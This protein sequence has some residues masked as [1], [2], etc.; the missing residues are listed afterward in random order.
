MGKYKWKELGLKYD[1]EDVRP[2]NDNDIENAK[3]ILGMSQ[4]N[5]LHK[6]GI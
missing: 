5:S 2:A 4:K 1:L 6:K 3:K